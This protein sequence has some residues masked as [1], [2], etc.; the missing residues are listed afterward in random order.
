MLEKS[1][2]IISLVSY[3]LAAPF[4]PLQF[5]DRTYLN[6]ERVHR[7]V[8]GTAALIFT[9]LLSSQVTTACLQVNRQARPHVIFWTLRARRRIFRGS[10]FSHVLTLAELRMSGIT[11]V[12]DSF[13]CHFSSFTCSAQHSEEQKPGVHYVTAIRRCGG[14]A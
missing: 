3:L 14:C 4:L 7:V 11:R 6:S 5:R 2:K 1:H 8:E 9:A 13:V 10:I 12:L